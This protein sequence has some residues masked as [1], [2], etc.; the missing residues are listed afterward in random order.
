[1]KYENYINRLAWAITDYT[2]L[3]LVKTSPVRC[4]R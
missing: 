4:E 1:M 3:K 2:L